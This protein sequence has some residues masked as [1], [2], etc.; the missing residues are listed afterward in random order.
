MSH[1]LTMARST[2]HALLAALFAALLT[3]VAAGS[4]YADIAGKI[5]R[6]AGVASVVRGEQTV[7]LGEGAEVHTNDRLQTGSQTGLEITFEDDT[8]LT[9][10]A[11]AAITIDAYVYDPGKSQGTVLIGVVKGAFRFTTGKLSAMTDK[12]VEVNTNF[13]SLAVRGTDFWAGPLDGAYGVLL[14]TGKVDVKTRVGTTPLDDPREGTMV[15]SFDQPPG[16]A[17]NWSDSKIERA[18]SQVEF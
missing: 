14:L 7:P 16:P 5:S 15:E 6:I 2:R 4:A 11:N 8:K 10:G 3:P 17:G 13:A 1:L 12:K 18:L 9:L